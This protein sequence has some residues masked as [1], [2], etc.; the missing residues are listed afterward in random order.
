AVLAA[1]C[2]P[3]MT[4]PPAP[5]PV[6]GKVVFADGQPLRGG[7]VTFNPIGDTSDRRYQGWGFVKKDGTY[8][9]VSVGSGVAP[10]PYKVT[11]GPKEEGEVR[12]SNARLVPRRYYTAETTP[13]NVDVTADRENVV[14]IRLQ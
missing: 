12:G 13:L 3:A 6:R 1:G 11:V 9:I 5:M 14:D 4:P 2:K 10:G 8:E 7:V